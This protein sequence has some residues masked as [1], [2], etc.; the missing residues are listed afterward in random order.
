M[1]IFF[2][3]VHM[4]APDETWAPFVFLR[5]VRVCMHSADL[6]LF[7]FSAMTAKPQQLPAT[8]SVCVWEWTHAYPK[9]GHGEIE[10]GRVCPYS[11]FRMSA[12]PGVYVC[13]C[14]CA[15][16]EC[17]HT[18][19]NGGCVCVWSLHCMHC[20]MCCN[21]SHRAV[22]NISGPSWEVTV[23]VYLSVCVF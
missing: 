21:I 11:C 10:L 20:R 8:V 2:R 5:C 15:H 14:E 23:C 4:H 9:C 19:R 17:G 13:V 1:T 7:W 16:C 3:P 18:E 12:Q 22:H 6:S